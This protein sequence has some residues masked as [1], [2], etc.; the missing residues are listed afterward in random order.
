[1]G[2]CLYGNDIDDTTSPIEAGLGWITK[3]TDHKEFTDKAVLKAQ[4]EQGTPRKLR[5]FV[6]NEKAIPRHD[7]EIEN[8]A[9]D[10][11]GIVTSG[12]MS[13]MMKQG[14]GLGYI[15]SSVNIGDEIYIRIRNKAL[16]ASVVKLPIYKG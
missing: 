13:P 2:F 3:F 14:I 5:G 8:A 1:M 7:Y 16:S 12:T 9:G 15:A 11:I 4:K 10:V 6:M